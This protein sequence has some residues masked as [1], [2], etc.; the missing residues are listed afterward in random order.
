MFY[1]ESILAKKGALSKVWLAAH[2]DKKLTKAQIHAA[3]IQTSVGDI[4]GEGVPP[5]ALRLSGQLL[6]G[7]VRIYSRKARYLLDDC[8]DAL[9]KFKMAF[10]PGMVEMTTEQAHAAHAAITL[11]NDNFSYFGGGIIGG[12]HIIGGGGGVDG[13]DNESIV[14]WTVGEDVVLTQYQQQQN[15]P[16]KQRTGSHAP[17]SIV[18]PASAKDITL[19]E[20]TELDGI[21]RL[22]IA[23][24]QHLLFSDANPDRHHVTVEHGAID[25]VPTD[26]HVELE[27]GLGEEFD[28]PHYDEPMHDMSAHE[29][30]LEVEVA[31]RESLAKDASLALINNDNDD[32]NVSLHAK[33][34]DTLNPDHHESVPLVDSFSAGE[35]FVADTAAFDGGDLNMSFTVPTA[36]DLPNFKKPTTQAAK[37]TGGATRKKRKPLEMDDMLELPSHVIAQQ[38]RDTL[39]I[40][41]QGSW[42]PVLALSHPILDKSTVLDPTVSVSGLDAPFGFVRS[43]RPRLAHAA[44]METPAMQ[45][46]AA[47]AP[48]ASP[49]DV[50]IEMPRDQQHLS[51]TDDAMG[52]MGMDDLDAL[53]PVPEEQSIELA[54]KSDLNELSHLSY[55]Q[56][57]SV[58]GD[59]QADMSLPMGTGSVHSSRQPMSSTGG[60]DEPGDVSLVSPLRAGQL[61]L[62]PSTLGDVAFDESASIAS[63]SQLQLRPEFTTAAAAD[64]S[65]SDTTTKLSKNTI[66]TI[67]LLQSKFSHDDDGSTGK[68]LLFSEVA[69][70]AK[71]ADVSKFFFECLV[72]STKN[73]ITVHQQSASSSYGDIEI[74]PVTENLFAVDLA[75]GAA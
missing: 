3:N 14:D 45:T 67:R 12:I 52:G 36:H 29:S 27:F 24:H 19:K 75:L 33:Q 30:S 20:T 69:H 9:V 41:T 65:G 44:V 50:S 8:N 60:M 4:I 71:R 70:N 18:Q 5:M 32:D 56:A 21:V 63:A 46:T 34:N 10:R 26:H 40:C 74:V 59:E 48:H 72:M 7:V 17:S 58:Y 22:S 53:A 38:L 43:V 42:M 49:H 39:A 68:T 66:K 47:A 62:R 31:R 6:L 73:L 64:E 57:G 23:T 51:F 37:K 55:S 11:N 28:M 25:K 15:T 13:Q 2:W 1:S 16:A 61:E 54:P 35:A